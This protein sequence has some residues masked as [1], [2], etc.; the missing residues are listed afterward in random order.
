MA[1]QKTYL[2]ET[3]QPKKTYL[4]ENG[5]PLSPSEISQAAA[6]KVQ[7]GLPANKSQSLPT[8]AGKA[9]PY[10]SSGLGVA[11][12]AAASAV[13][14]EVGALKYLPGLV[15]SG[16]MAAIQNLMEPKEGG[17]IKNTAVDTAV[18]EIGGRL[19]S[20]TAKVGGLLGGGVLGAVAPSIAEK[21]GVKSVDQ[22]LLKLKPTTSQLTDSRFMR[23]LEDTF[24]PIAKGKALLN[25]ANL[26]TKEAENLVK[27]MAGRS[28]INL[29]TINKQAENIATDVEKQFDASKFES[30]RRGAAAKL[31]AKANVI[32][33]PVYSSVMSPASA[34]LGPNGLPITGTATKVV[35]TGTENIEGPIFP[36]KVLVEA[37]KLLNDINK[38][39]IRPD[40]NSPLVRALESIIDNNQATDATGNLGVKPRNF[41]DMWETK[42]AIDDIAYGRPKSQ[43]DFVD[44]RFK[45]LAHA[46]NEDIDDSMPLWKVNGDIAQRVWNESKHIVAKRNE[47]FNKAPVEKLVNEISEQ[48]PVIDK[49][50][51]NPR[52]LQRTLMTGNLVIPSGGTKDVTNIKYITSNT[53]KDL[54]GYELTQLINNAK[55]VDTKGNVTYDGKKLVE[56][57]ADPNKQESYRILFSKQNRADIEQFFKNIAQVSDKTKLGMGNYWMLRLGGTGLTLGATLATALTTGSLPASVGTGGAVIGATLGANQL[58]KLLTNPDS[59]RLMVALAQNGPLNKSIGFAGRVI[60]NVLKNSPV[61]INYQDGNSINGKI[62]PDGKFTIPLE[63]TGAKK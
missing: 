35:Q 19:I 38:S 5:E 12:G 48:V 6:S 46:I 43:T 34:V 32:Q 57:F 42:Q 44:G 52:E 63:T 30:N 36:N 16:T 11:A 8:L 13:V 18:N 60:A 51:A 3:G 25:S 58:G 55:I 56:S 14:P 4:N 47:L 20:G 26:S 28:D 50:I 40:P 45:K 53:R 9:A 23:W 7:V 62:G 24:S 54:Q 27:S 39:D 1:Q 10:V 15:G 29:S 61:T 21:F 59:A 37:H 49:V 31:I 41:G 22:N 2:D 33:L 17:F